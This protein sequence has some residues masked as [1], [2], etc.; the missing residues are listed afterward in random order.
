MIV[1]RPL[2]GT[3]RA[4]GVDENRD[5]V[6]AHGGGALFEEGIPLGRRRQARAPQRQDVLK[7]DKALVGVLKQSARIEDDDLA[8]SRYAR[9]RIQEL[10]DK[11]LIFRAEKIGFAIFKLIFDLIDRAGR[12]DAVTD[13]AA[14]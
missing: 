2:G 6:R 12:I 7:A 5:V 3:G 1:H 11:L 9:F 8:N 13:R 4:G 14:A 10:V